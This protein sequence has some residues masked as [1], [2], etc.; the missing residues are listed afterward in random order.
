MKTVDITSE[1]LIG[2]G[3]YNC[4]NSCFFNSVNQM[5][6]HI[7]EI[8]E[9]LIRHKFLFNDNNI[10]LN[11]I[12][13]FECMKLSTIK[14]NAGTLDDNNPLNQDTELFDKN[15]KDFYGDVQ[16]KYFNFNILTARKKKKPI[17]QQD[18]HELYQHYFAHDY[19]SINKSINSKIGI[20]DDKLYNYFDIYSKINFP[21]S[22]LF[23]PEIKK[24]T[25]IYNKSKK[26]DDDLKISNLY[27]H[28]MYES[29]ILNINKKT[30]TL[31][32][33]NECKPPSG[34]NTNQETTIKPN[35]YLIIRL[36]KDGFD[37][38]GNQIIN[39]EEIQNANFPNV[40]ISDD[41]GNDYEMVGTICK[42]GPPEGG[43]YWYYHKVESVWYEFNDSTVSVSD[44]INKYM[45]VCVF[46]RI[47]ADYN[48]NIYSDI[49]DI[50]TNL[51]NYLKTYTNTSSGGN[52][53]KIQEY[54][55]ILKFISYKHNNNLNVSNN[56]LYIE[57]MTNL[58]SKITGLLT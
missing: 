17:Q 19:N 47:G 45:L 50:E 12:S 6:F 14:N 20:Y 54:I 21:I 2:S 23:F 9:F 56:K 3:V 51:L 37:N 13:L 44:P 8:R 7:P 39:Y 29:K 57:V 16:L 22:D 38:I 4:G 58:K 26:I 40:I 43:H 27:Y 42:Y 33:Y 25:C 5:I 34:T 41:D 30:E 48:I 31:D 18:T 52:E 46:R 24:K 35:K 15:I 49:N 28:N 32:D 36:V 1:I 53:H 11:L 10:I 55:N